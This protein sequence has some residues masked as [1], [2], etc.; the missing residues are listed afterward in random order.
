MSLVKSG[1]VVRRLSAV[2]G[3]AIRFNKLLQR[4]LVFALLQAVSGSTEVSV[5][6]NAASAP[7]NQV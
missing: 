7:F 6:I 2:P 3:E 5:G 1:Y 4:R